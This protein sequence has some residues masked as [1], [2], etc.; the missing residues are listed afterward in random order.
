MTALPASGRV[1]SLARALALLLSMGL[2]AC[3]R[4]AAPTTTPATDAP[5]AQPPAGGALFSPDEPV[6]VAEAFATAM[7]PDDNIDSLAAWHAPDGAVWLFATAKSTDQLLVYDGLTGETLRSFGSRGEGSGQ[8]RRPNGVVVA[9]DLLF[10]IERDNRRVQLLRLPGFEHVL[11]FGQAELAKPY[12][13]WVN[14]SNGGYEV[15]VTDAYGGEDDAGNDVAMPIGEMDRRLRQYRIS[16]E[17]AQLQAALV[18]THGDTSEAG[19]L[20]VVESL[21]GDAANN[22]LLIAEEDEAYANEIKVYDL[23]GTFTGT[24]M[25]KGTFRAQVEGL[26]LKTCGDG[27]GWWI[28]TQQGKDFSVF[29]LFNRQSLDYVASFRGDQVAN[30]DGIWLDTRPSERFPQGALYAVHDDQGAVAFDWR[31]V[32]S[33]LMLPECPQ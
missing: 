14:R 6:R 29:H 7:T 19:A 1:N 2:V 31:T 5:T 16:G 8:F 4:A 23:A 20:R 30:T 9:D 26:Q 22:R 17:G 25:G 18:G 10:V 3:D 28:G 15:Y 11:S 33:A 24:I 32:R 13:A 21:W 27:G 12:G